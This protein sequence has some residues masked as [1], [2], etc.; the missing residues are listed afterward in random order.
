MTFVSSYFDSDITMDT[1]DSPDMIHN[2]SNTKMWTK[3]THDMYPT[4]ETTLLSL[5]LGIKGSSNEV[6]IQKSFVITRDYMLYQKSSCSAYLRSFKAALCLAWTRI[7][8]VQVEDEKVLQLG[9]TWLMSAIKNKKFTTIYIK[10]EKDMLALKSCLK[11]YTISADFYEDY[12]V[13][14]KLGN[15]ASASVKFFP[16]LILLSFFQILRIKLELNLKASK[17]L[18]VF[19]IRKKFN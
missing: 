12:E 8:F 11:K 16:S 18:I 6:V 4:P 2:S 13:V 9:Y 7:S 3:P 14:G 15:G 1:T 19:F 5:N 10:T 17:F